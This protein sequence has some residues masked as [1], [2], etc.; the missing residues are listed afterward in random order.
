LCGKPVRGGPPAA[1]LEEERS[2]GAAACPRLSPGRLLRAPL[3]HGGTPA[4]LLLLMT[5]LAKPALDSRGVRDVPQ[6]TVVVPTR[7]R[8]DSVVRAVSAL[9]A[10][11]PPDV[12]IVIVDQSV[13]DSTRAA[14][15]E[16]RARSNVRYLKTG[17]IG[18]AM[19]RNIG[20]GQAR[21]EIVGLTDDDCE[22]RAD[23]IRELVAGFAVDDRMAVVFGSV[24][25]AAHDGDAGFVPAHMGRAEFLACRPSEL[26]KVDGMAACMGLR[27][28]A[29]N[30]LGGFDTA[31]GS[32]TSLRSGAEGDLALRAL[33]AGYF[34]YANPRLE[35]LHHGFR[36]WEEGRPLIHSYFYG[37]GAMLAK[38]VHRGQLFAAPLLGRLAWRWAF[39]RS[40]VAAGLGSRPQRWFRLG[41]FLRGFA[42]GI[43]TPIDR[44]SG[45]Y[46]PRRQSTDGGRG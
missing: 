42:A 40:P 27:R 15:A 43:L 16:F 19:A 4:Y 12:E 39:G 17:G 11:D 41:A 31:L 24:A 37:T 2:R 45:H 26:P 30:A 36:T 28:S 5:P 32:G 35:V 10:G 44:A 22:A 33:R 9:L 46:R 7:N 23:W 1:D 8:S 29:W 34:V 18:S 3:I 13:D 20:V 21:A 38:P 14:L 6:A 25:A